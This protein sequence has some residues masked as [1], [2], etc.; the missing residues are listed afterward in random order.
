MADFF[1][2]S[3][4]NYSGLSSETKPTIAAGNVVPNG[5]RWRE[6]DT[7][8]VWFFNLSDDTWYVAAPSV[9]QSTH[10]LLTLEY[11]HHEIHG[12]SGYM[13]SYNVTLAG[14]LGSFVFITTPNTTK[15]AHFIWSISVSAA[16]DAYLY[17][18]YTGS[19]GT[20]L[21]LRN[22]NRNSANTS[23]LTIT[24]TPIGAADGTIIWQD[25]AGSSGF[26]S[27][28]PGT[29][30]ARAEVILKQNEKYLFRVDGANGDIVTYN[31]DWYEHTDKA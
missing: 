28:A 4:N 1:E 29:S 23:G 18:T 19:G 9:D 26:L 14:G 5:S 22:R 20:G 2:Q 12:G 31:F 30:N 17:E 16:F 8:K 24:H 27:S 7:E 11:P 10:A 3:I 25:S 6:V 13:I 21:T 15:W